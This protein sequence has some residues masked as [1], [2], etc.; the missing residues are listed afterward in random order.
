MPY[1]TDMRKLKYKEQR[2]FL[3][4]V[5]A[6]LGCANCD[7]NEHGAAIDFH[8]VV[9]DS[10]VFT[11]GMRTLVSLPRIFDEMAK[12]VALCS[13]CHRVEHAKET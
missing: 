9:E 4:S 1:S 13:N 7:Y 2:D 6:L 8:H 11:L 5:K 3:R 10:K 12:C